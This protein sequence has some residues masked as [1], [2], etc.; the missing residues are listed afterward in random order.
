MIS[1]CLQ[2]SVVL[3]SEKLHEF[4]D[5]LLL[6]Q[7]AIYNLQELEPKPFNIE[8]SIVSL[9]LVRVHKL[10]P[11]RHFYEGHEKLTSC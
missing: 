2:H 1:N 10:Y 6:M 4:Y 11:F 8:P 9:A 7:Y 3:Q 5:A